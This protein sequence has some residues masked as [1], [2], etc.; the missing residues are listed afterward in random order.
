MVMGWM[1]TA[2]SFGLIMDSWDNMR[3][4]IEVTIWDER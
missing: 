2:D 1:R 4:E 3:V